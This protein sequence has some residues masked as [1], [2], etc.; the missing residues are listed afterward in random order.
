[1][2]GRGT[3]GQG[4][5]T[6]AQVSR[7]ALARPISGLASKPETPP[8]SLPTVVRIVPVE[9]G[10]LVL[11]QD[12]GTSMLANHDFPTEQ[13]A[14][15]ALMEMAKQGGFEVFVKY[16]DNGRF[17]YAVVGRQFPTLKS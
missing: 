8:M 17:D 12:D 3:M 13:I 9:G 5:R 16:R 14:V 2:D 7:P 11:M 6:L 1:M 10:R 4:L 15:D